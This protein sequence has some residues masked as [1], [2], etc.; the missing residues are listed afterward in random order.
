M[1]VTDFDSEHSEKCVA[2]K[3]WNIHMINHLWLEESYAKWEVQSLSNPKYNYFPARTNLT[4]VV[5][6]TPIDARALRQFYDEESDDEKGTGSGSDDDMVH[7]DNDEAAEQL[8]AVEIPAPR[9]PAPLKTAK[10]NAL[11][12]NDSVRRKSA[13]VTPASRHSTGGYTDGTPSSVMSSGRRAKEA[14]ASKLHESINDMNLYEK[15]KKRKGGVLGIGRKRRSSVSDLETSFSD[16]RATGDEGPPQYVKPASPKKI[17]L[18]TNSR[19]KKAKRP[20]ASVKLLVT[21]YT[22]WTDERREE[23][24][25]VKIR[26]RTTSNYKANFAATKRALLDLGIQLVD[27][28]EQC[29]HLAAPKLVRTAKFVC[30]LARSPIIVTTKWF[31]ACIKEKELVDVD[32]Y[33]LKDKATETRLGI[34]L[35]ASL[36]R[37]KQIGGQLLKGQTIYIAP[38]IPPGFDTCKKIVEA[39]GGVCV[40][41]TIGKRITNANTPQSPKLVLLS[42]DAPGDQ[43]Y[44]K[45]FSDMAE[46]SNAKPFIYSMDWLLDVTMNQR[47]EWS[48]KF[49][50]PQTK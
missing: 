46:S 12:T 35:K 20:K 38:N 5:G 31:E 18:T 36:Q 25:R 16:A 42:S 24:D 14:A 22:E 50:V 21:G 48:G 26:K 43:K 10:N 33:I 40:S 8:K 3:E 23:N 1:I 6:M 17:K 11:T 41:F 9:T 27:D 4:E 44:W 29:T 39:N 30:A 28:P 45:K 15:E 32:R 37:A 34:D 47:I 19:A 2:A 7:A 49:L 13:L